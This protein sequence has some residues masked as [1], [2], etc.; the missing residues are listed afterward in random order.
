[1]CIAAWNREKF[2]KIPY[3]GGSGSFKVIDVDIIPK[4]PVA[5]A[6]YVLLLSSRSC[7]PFWPKGIKILETPGYHMVKTRSLYL[8]WAWN[9][10]PGRD[11]RTD[12]RTDR[13][14]VAN[15]R[16]L[17][18]LVALAHKK[19]PGEYLAAHLVQR[20]F[21]YEEFWVPRC[22]LCYTLFHKKHPFSFF[23]NSVK[24]WSIHTKFLPDVAEEIL[25]QNIWTKY[26]C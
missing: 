13:I 15:T 14:T 18:M 17:A 23:C 12:R 24:W 2:T 22:T 25:I 26:G 11:T 4:K 3:F 9:G 21:A 10:I 8:T 7:G 19:A 5:S 16:H 1:M 20:N 6:C